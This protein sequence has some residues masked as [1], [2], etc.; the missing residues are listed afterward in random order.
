MTNTN[1]LV[2]AVRKM[3]IDPYQRI[4]LAIVAQAIQDYTAL[5]RRADRTPA[6]ERERIACRE[7]ILSDRFVLYTSGRVD[8]QGLLNRLNQ[9]I[10][11]GN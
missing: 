11:S 6:Q 5:S 9:K 4:A 7:F 8:G 2:E 1:N 10:S 3:D